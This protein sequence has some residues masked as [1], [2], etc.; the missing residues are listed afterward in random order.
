DPF[1]FLSNPFL[2]I[3]LFQT[4]NVPFCYILPG[5]ERKNEL[6]HQRRR[7]TE[8]LFKGE[9]KM[10]KVLKPDFHINIRRLPP[11]FFDQVIGVV[12]SFLLQPPV[13]RSLENFFKVPFESGKTPAG[14]ISKAVEVYIVFV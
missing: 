3:P 14:E 10:R 5:W 2:Y 6:N 9:R 1:I 12:Q 11:L 4:A 7:Y 8:C 13:R